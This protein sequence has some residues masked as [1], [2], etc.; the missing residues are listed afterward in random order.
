MNNPQRKVFALDDGEGRETSTPSTFQS[1][2]DL[3][4][5]IT[6]R[7]GQTRLRNDNEPGWDAADN[8]LPVKKEGS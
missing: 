1:I 3:V 5:R 4:E 6:R 8:A 7:V 2:G